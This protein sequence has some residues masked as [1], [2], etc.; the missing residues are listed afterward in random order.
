M[1]G[2]PEGA[3]VQVRLGDLRQADEV[4]AAGNISKV[5]RDLRFDDVTPESH[6]L[7]DRVRESNWRWAVTGPRR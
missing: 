6:A 1:M 3:Q 5:T 7:P 2:L 4:C